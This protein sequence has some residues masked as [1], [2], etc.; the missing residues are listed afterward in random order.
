MIGALTNRFEFVISNLLN[1]SEQ[2]A[3]ARSSIADA[4]FGVEAARL[5]K[6]QVLQQSGSAILAQANA[7]PQMVLSLI[8]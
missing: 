5:A 2:T 3:S 1:V 8:R 7:L 4:D 6:A